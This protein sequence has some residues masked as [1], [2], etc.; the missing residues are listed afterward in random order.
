MSLNLFIYIYIHIYKCV[1]VIY[2]FPSLVLFWDQDDFFHRFVG[3]WYKPRFRSSASSWPV[4]VSILQSMQ[5]GCSHWAE[6]QLDRWT[7]NSFCWHVLTL[8]FKMIFLQK[9]I[10]IGM[11]EGHRYICRSYSSLWILNPKYEDLLPRLV[12]YLHRSSV[13]VQPDIISSWA[14]GNEACDPRRTW[15]SNGMCFF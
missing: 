1:Y 14:W 8:L 3:T 13:L 10:F 9:C 2:L 7:P 15:P 4:A 5:L 12:G 11:S 6:K